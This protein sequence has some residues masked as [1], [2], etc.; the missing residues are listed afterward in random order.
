VSSDRFERAVQ[1]VDAVNADDPN[2]VEYDGRTWPKELL[3]GRLVSEWVERLRPD[4]SEALRL[5]ARAHHIR[6]WVVPRAGYPNGRAGYLRW[7][8]DLHRMHAE[9]VGCILADV[10]YPPEVITRVEAIVQKRDLRTDSEVQTFEDALCLVFAQTQL[11]D[12]ASR[13]DRDKLVEVL[14]KTLAK[15]SQAGRDA[16]TSLPL[17]D[18]TQ[19]LVAEAAQAD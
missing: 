13:L 1:A 8:R 10:G 9:Q 18:E 12:L 14:R 11:A 15:M 2:K 4:A 3:H 5:A 7:R 16:L 19:R 6:R 17:T